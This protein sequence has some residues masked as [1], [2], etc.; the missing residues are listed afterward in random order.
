MA[1]STLGL[2]NSISRL[3]N[4]QLNTIKRI[5][6]GLKINSAQDNA[7]AYTITQSMSAKLLAL[8]Q[9]SR[10]VQTGNAFLNTASGSVGSTVNV[11]K[12]MKENLLN[13]ANGTN[14]PS[15]INALKQ[16]LD[17][18]VKAI[19]DNS[20]TTFNN[21]YL[22]DGSVEN[23][24]LAGDS[25]TYTLSIGDMSAKGLGLVDENGNSTLDLS[26][27]D[28]IKNAID[29]VDAALQ[30]ALTQQSHIGAV[31]QGLSY[32]D[33]SYTD[34]AE[35][36]TDAISTMAD[37]D[38]AKES[39]KLKSDNTLEQ[40]NYFMMSQMFKNNANVLALLS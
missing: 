21:K 30:S 38:I 10:N 4:S 22:T 20:Q 35:N 9:S 40:A 2:S 15:D 36:L 25:G 1:I 12:D 23:L 8:G 5:S 24:V 18:S 29:T 31:Q 6:T 27:Q 7:S 28:G 19:D 11:L 34:S 33:Y 32:T 37:A 26:S 3:H 16:K 39:I 14:S 13:A 17:Q